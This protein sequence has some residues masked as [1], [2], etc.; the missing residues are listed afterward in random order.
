VVS[1]TDTS[2]ELSKLTSLHASG[3]ISDEEFESMKAK[4]PQS[5]PK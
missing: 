5:T 1:D 2:S 3:V 4:L